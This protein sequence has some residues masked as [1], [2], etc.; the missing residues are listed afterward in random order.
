MNRLYKLRLEL[1]LELEPEPEPEL[2]LFFNQ[3]PTI[4]RF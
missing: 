2:K 4:C 1:E 3:T